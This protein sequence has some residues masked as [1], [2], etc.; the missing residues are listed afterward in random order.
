M[1]NI[2]SIVCGSNEEKC[3]G[4]I[5]NCGWQY[6]SCPV[7]GKGLQ[8]HENYKPCELAEKGKNEKEQ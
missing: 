5:G 4:T 6:W 8:S 2:C 1:E 7:C 3:P